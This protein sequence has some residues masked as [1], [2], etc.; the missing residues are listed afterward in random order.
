MRYNSSALGLDSGLLPFFP[1]ISAA[2]PWAP[3]ISSS[4]NPRKGNAIF[5]LLLSASSK[6]IHHSMKHLNAQSLLNGNKNQT[7]NNEKTR[8][9]T[10]PNSK[11]I[12]HRRVTFGYTKIKTMFSGSSR[13]KGIFPSAAGHSHHRLGQNSWRTFCFQGNSFVVF[14]GVSL[15]ISRWYLLVCCGFFPGYPNFH[16]HLLPFGMHTALL[17]EGI[18]HISFIFK[19]EM[20]H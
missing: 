18:K 4:Q 7:I 17:D 2:L 9:G 6:Q 12:K 11:L 14:K 8:E 20:I 1:E 10:N 16:P 15:W 3:L 13:E 5:L 19:F